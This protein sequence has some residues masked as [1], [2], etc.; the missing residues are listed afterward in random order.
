MNKKSKLKRE[1]FHLEIYIKI[2]KIKIQFRYQQNLMVI[3]IP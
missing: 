1:K 2:M 3:N